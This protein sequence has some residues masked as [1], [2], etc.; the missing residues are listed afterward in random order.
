MS[1]FNFYLDS[2]R[3]YGLNCLL[4]WSIYLFDTIVY[5]MARKYC[6]GNLWS[7]LIAYMYVY[8][9]EWCPLNRHDVVF[10]QEKKHVKIVNLK[11]YWEDKVTKE[12]TEGKFIDFHC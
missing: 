4:L 12:D 8:V 3:F 1:F 7:N 5:G 10:R 9:F 11:S 2:Y 6:C